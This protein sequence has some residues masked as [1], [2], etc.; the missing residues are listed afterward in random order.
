MAL[1]F[2]KQCCIMQQ[3]QEV[4]LSKWI[5]TD[6]P[7]PHFLWRILSLGVIN[8]LISRFSSLPC[9]TNI[10]IILTNYQLTIV[11]ICVCI[12]LLHNLLTLYQ[13]ILEQAYHHAAIIATFTS[14]PYIL[15]SI[16]LDFVMFCGN[17]VFCRNS[18]KK[19][20]I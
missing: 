9:I 2:K 4:H 12:Y 3:W 7:R 19:I 10:T 18:K 11:F 8:S 15:V 5:Y 13:T 17:N 20:L 6:E 1:S 14:H 16:L